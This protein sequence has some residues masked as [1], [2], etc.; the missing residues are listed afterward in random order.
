M[1]RLHALLPPA[2]L[3]VTGL[4]LPA[5]GPA[6]RYFGLSLSAPVSPDEQARLASALR[7]DGPKTGACRWQPAGAETAFALPCR[8]VP[9][10]ALARL[11]AANDKQAQLELGIRFEE[12]IGVERDRML[13]ASSIAWL[14]GTAIRARRSAFRTIRAI[15]SIR[16]VQWTIPPM[17][18][19]MPGAWHPGGPRRA[20][21]LKHVRGWRR[22]RRAS[23]RAWRKAGMGP[24]NPPRTGA[25]RSSRIKPRLRNILP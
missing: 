10:V 21:F 7:D 4:L 24:I 11:A 12:G 8:D 18:R 9:L 17:T 16:P 1:A 13:P 15:C 14:R 2:I 5:C 3:L 6:D 20:A 22:L 19:A 25:C 23:A